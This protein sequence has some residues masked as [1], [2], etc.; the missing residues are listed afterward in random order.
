[1]LILDFQPLGTYAWP[2]C[3]DFAGQAILVLHFR[4]GFTTLLKYAY[5]GTTMLILIFEFI[6]LYT[7]YILLRVKNSGDSLFDDL[8]DPRPR[9]LGFTEV[10]KIPQK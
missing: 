8:G 3:F 4:R 2:F 1:M 9:K 10:W 7:C 6:N 5:V